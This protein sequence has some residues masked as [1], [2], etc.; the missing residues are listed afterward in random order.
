M[1]MK[2]CRTDVLKPETLASSS[3]LIV[4]FPCALALNHVGTFDSSS[5]Q[6][7]VPNQP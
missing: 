7:V 5:Y 3:H 6:G 1:S 4:S 2:L